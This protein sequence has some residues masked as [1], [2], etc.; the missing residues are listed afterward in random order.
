MSGLGCRNV[1]VCAKCFPFFLSEYAVVAP[2][3]HQI[4]M[5]VSY[6]TVE[7]GKQTKNRQRENFQISARDARNNYKYLR[8]N[9]SARTESR[10]PTLLPRQALLWR[11]PAYTAEGTDHITHGVPQGICDG[12][13]AHQ[14]ITL[15][16]E[17]RANPVRLLEV[18]GGVVGHSHCRHAHLG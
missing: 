10:I 6:S 5:F 9:L 7:P 3:D 14:E 13:G 2:R 4:R 15:V 1:K 12:C 17:A 8:H 18:L 16:L 11:L